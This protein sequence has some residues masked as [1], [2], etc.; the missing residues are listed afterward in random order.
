VSLFFGKRHVPTVDALPPPKS[1]FQRGWFLIKTHLSKF[2]SLNIL[3]LVFCLPVVTIPAAFAATNRVCLVLWREGNCFLWEEF[4]SEFKREFIR[5]LL[6]GIPAVCGIGLMAL[7]LILNGEGM[8]VI[9]AWTLRILFAAGGAWCSAVTS[10]AFGML[11]LI[12]LP[13]GKI[14]SNALFLTMLEPKRTFGIVVFGSGVVLLGGFFLPYTL[15]LCLF[16]W[17][18]FWQFGV[19]ALSYGPIK[20]RVLASNESCPMSPVNNHTARTARR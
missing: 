6:V 15:P 1:G 8:S 14:L 4:W 7:G 9:A 20:R 17:C 16:I 12:R 13:V 2:I 10:Y 18:A 5:A 19:S 11:A 3:F